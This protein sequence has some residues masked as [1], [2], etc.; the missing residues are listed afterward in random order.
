MTLV[1]TFD[2][3][4][5]LRRHLRD[6]DGR[7]KPELSDMLN[8]AVRVGE[9]SAQIYAPSRTHRLER[10]I[11]SVPAHE[12]ASIG[13]IEA[14]VGVDPVDGYED[15][16]PDYPFLVNIGTGLF[17]PLM[18]YITPIRASHMVFTDR[19]F[20]VAKRIRG[21]HPQPYMD[22]AFEDVDNYLDARIDLMVER[23]IGY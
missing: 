9:Q 16:S 15:G 20:V 18:D 8:E 5:E 11:S 19:K 1:R 10:A 12:R 3:L 21:Q 23:I 13:A 22:Q 6:M 4:G 14:S 7:V 17:G 2:S